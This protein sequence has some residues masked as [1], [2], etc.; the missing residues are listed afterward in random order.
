MGRHL[1]CLREILRFSSLCGFVYGPPMDTMLISCPK[2][3]AG[4]LVEKNSA[5]PECQGKGT[6]WVDIDEWIPLKRVVR[7]EGLPYHNPSQS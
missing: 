6:V 5:C 3:T 2:C 1:L 4:M 7:M